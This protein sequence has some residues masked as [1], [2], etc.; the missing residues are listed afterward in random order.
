M[1]ISTAYL[2][3]GGGRG[4]LRAQ[5]AILSPFEEGDPLLSSSAA[6]GPGGR[7]KGGGDFLI[8]GDGYK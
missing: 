5:M 4:G 6:R 1:E 8:E 2:L 7:F 3:Q